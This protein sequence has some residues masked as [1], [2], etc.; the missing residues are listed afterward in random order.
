MGLV[1]QV[2]NDNGLVAY[3]SGCAW[4]FVAI[5][6]KEEEM[7]VKELIEALQK[8]PEDLEVRM[9]D[10]KIDA[11]LLK[12]EA[13]VGGNVDYHECDSYVDFI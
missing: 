5:P 13:I 1:P 8:C 2:C 12:E 9:R 6:K 7:T 4:W 11:V 10:A 3:Y